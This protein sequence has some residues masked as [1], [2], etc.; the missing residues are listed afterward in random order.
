M[1]VDK[2]LLVVAARNGLTPPTELDPGHMLER[3]TL[4]EL[5]G[6]PFD[7]QYV[8]GQIQDHEVQVALFEDAARE[9]QN[10]EIR[11]FAQQHLPQIQQHLEM[12]RALRPQVVRGS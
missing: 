5:S 11:A 9:A 1:A 3:K 10:P 4:A 2:D 12:A 8:L 7:E 6:A